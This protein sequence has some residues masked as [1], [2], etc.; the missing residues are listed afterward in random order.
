MCAIHFLD[1]SV[2]KHNIKVFTD[3]QV[4]CHFTKTK[5]VFA[6]GGVCLQQKGQDL[7]GCVLHGTQ[8]MPIYKEA[9]NA[10]MFFLHL[11]YTCMINIC[12]DY[13][14]NIKCVYCISEH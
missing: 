6:P 3:H 7:D 4:Q 12:T 1:E 14:M 13:I 10:S 9:I 2:N 5:V 8:E 11:F